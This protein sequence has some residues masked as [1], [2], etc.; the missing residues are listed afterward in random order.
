MKI[1][2]SKI[3]CCEPEMQGPASWNVIEII[4]TMQMAHREGIPL[5]R[6][7]YLDKFQKIIIAILTIL[8]GLVVMLATLEIIYPTFR[9]YVPIS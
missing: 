7:S 2:W 1:D 9:S 8:M 4:I 3:W 5:M 6:L